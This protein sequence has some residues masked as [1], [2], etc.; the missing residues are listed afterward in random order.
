MPYAFHPPVGDDQWH[1]VSL[2]CDFTLKPDKKFREPNAL[3]PAFFGIPSSS[4]RI[5]KITYDIIVN[6]C[7]N[8]STKM[9][10]IQLINTLL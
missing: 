8:I 5:E 2:T 9:E 10:L 4:W 7:T 3:N 6:D 1:I